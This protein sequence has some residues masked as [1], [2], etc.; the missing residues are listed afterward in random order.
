M[1]HPIRREPSRHPSD[2][3][4]R[5]V[6]ERARWAALGST[7]LGPIALG[8]AACL[9]AAS[10]VLVYESEFLVRFDAEPETRAQLVAIEYEVRGS[11]GAT[12]SVARVDVA[13][14][15]GLPSSPLP[16]RPLGGDWHRSFLVT[17]RAL[18]DAG[19]GA[20]EP[21]NERSFRAA[22][23]PRGPGGRQE[24]T[25]TFSD[26]C[27]LFQRA[28]AADETCIDGRCEPIPFVS[29]NGPREAHEPLRVV[30]VDSAEALADAVADARFGD[31]IVVEPGSYELT[32]NLRTAR[33]GSADAPI[34]VRARTPGT[35]ILRYSGEEPAEVFVITHP[36]W[37]IDGLD[38]EGHCLADQ[39][40]DHAVHVSGSGRYTVLRNNRF[41]DFNQ[42][43]HVNPASDGRTPDDG[44]LEGNVLEC[45][46]PRP[47]SVSTSVTGLR[48]QG[49]SR[50]IFRDN[51]FR[52]VLYDGH[53]STGAYFLGTSEGLVLERNLVEVRRELPVG[54]SFLGLSFGTVAAGQ[55][56]GLV[57]RNTI[58]RSG[59]VAIQNCESCRVEHTLVVGDLDLRA[60]VE[61]TVIG[62]LVTGRRR[63]AAAST[64]DE[65]ESVFERPLAELVVDPEDDLRP[66]P[67]VP[68]LASDVADDLCGDPRPS[69]RTAGPLEPSS[70]CRG[71]DAPRAR[72]LP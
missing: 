27:I 51:V 49:A 28:C 19:G 39:D 69:R 14:L 63:V 15:G 70:A 11:D 20:L 17:A 6:F 2:R 37:V 32:R 65:R 33:G 60:G 55:Q 42:I 24:Y 23:A 8:L 5:P 7:A 4:R 45:T 47:S 58:V 57:L 43:V 41:A 48:F 12:E 34:V 50:W 53:G 29:P 25:L 61:L 72:R 64:V 22:F 36:Y 16:I 46:R 30:T 3:R 9:S 67:S 26:D 38:I 54:S 71:T 59:G 56:R 10:C 1:T 40:C 35:A 62:A 66:L 21:F 13:D 18:R 44:I 52:D 68:T 31:E